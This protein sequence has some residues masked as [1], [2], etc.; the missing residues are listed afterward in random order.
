[1]YQCVCFGR[2][3]LTCLAPLKLSQFR[4][5]QHC[6]N[7]CHV[8]RCIVTLAGGKDELTEIL[9]QHMLATGNFS[10]IISVDGGSTGHQGYGQ[11][12]QGAPDY[13][14]G[15]TPERNASVGVTNNN[16]S[17]PSGQQ[18]VGNFLT[19]SANSPIL[20]MHAVDTHHS[21]CHGL[22]PRGLA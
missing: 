21:L 3:F 14:Y 18:N 19:V 5:Q 6:Y 10:M 9:K 13:T 20:C 16:Y 17:R 4:H 7:T 22:A 12:P 2:L 8:G 1:M 15:G 11:A